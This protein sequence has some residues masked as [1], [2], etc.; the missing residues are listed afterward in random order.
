MKKGKILL[1]DAVHPDFQGM[2][3]KQSFSVDHATIESE[4]QLLKTVGGYVG[5]VVRSSPMISGNIIDRADRLRFIARAGS[6]IENIDYTHA[7]AGELRFSI[8]PRETGMQL[9]NMLLAL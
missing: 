5:I 7:K 8:L 3:E 9:E 6:G 4:E 2:L 1:L